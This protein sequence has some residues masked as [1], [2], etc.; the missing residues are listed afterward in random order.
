MH[1][2]YVQNIAESL[3][4]MCMCPTATF[5][6]G[7]FILGQAEAVYSPNLGLIWAVMPVTTALSFII[8]KKV[9]QL[10]WCYDIQFY[11]FWFHIIYQ[12]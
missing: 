12:N 3:N 4:G 9:L 7:G 11:L 1:L 10:V 5:V 8:G 6:G 2:K